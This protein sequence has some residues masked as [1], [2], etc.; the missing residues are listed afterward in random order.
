MNYYQIADLYLRKTFEEY[1][2]HIIGKNGEGL[3]GVAVDITLTSIY[4]KEGRLYKMSSDDKGVL[5]LGSLE[6]V[7]I[8]EAKMGSSERSWKIDALKE[9]VS[10]PGR[11]SMRSS[12]SIQVPVVGLGPVSLLTMVGDLVVKRT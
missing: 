11:I 12:D 6:D 8:L 3:S 4:Y 9:Q 10:Y 2:I 7:E 1:Q 5:H